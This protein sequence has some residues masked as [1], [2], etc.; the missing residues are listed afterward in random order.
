[1]IISY[2][3]PIILKIKEHLLTK[4]TKN[5]FK[6]FYYKPYFNMFNVLDHLKFIRINMIKSNKIIPT[7]DYFM[8]MLDIY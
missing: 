4:I 3:G 2:L 1:M 6:Y 5:Y 8:E 7:S